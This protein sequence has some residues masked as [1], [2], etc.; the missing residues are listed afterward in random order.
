MST[1]AMIIKC[2]RI[3]SLDM[4]QPVMCIWVLYIF[5]NCTDTYMRHLNHTSNI[6]MQNAISF[7]IMWWCVYLAWLTRIFSNS[8]FSSSHVRG[9]IHLNP[10]SRKEFQS[11]PSLRKYFHVFLIFL[12]H[13]QTFYLILLLLFCRLWDWGWD[14]SWMKNTKWWET[15]HKHSTNPQ[16][17]IIAL[18]ES[19]GRMEISV[20]QEN[21]EFELFCYLC[22]ILKLWNE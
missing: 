20:F 7:I 9:Y 3:C 16:F 8:C 14:R 11:A 21:F 10:E 6:A 19:F 5:C 13:P 4:P 17:K 15:T 2:M 18:P 1:G 12:I 22:E